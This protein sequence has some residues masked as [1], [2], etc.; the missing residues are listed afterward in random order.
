MHPTQCD[1]PAWRLCLATIY[2]RLSVFAILFFLVDYGVGQAFLP[3]LFNTKSE[4]GTVAT[5]VFVYV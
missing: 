2:P 1:D 5:G 4:P 3:V